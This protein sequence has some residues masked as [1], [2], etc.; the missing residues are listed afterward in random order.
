MKKQSSSESDH[1]SSPLEEP[2]FPA[3]VYSETVLAVNF[4]DSKK[5]FLEALL[6]IHA[7]HT[8]MLAR[9]GII[10][11]DEASTCL[12]ALQQLDLQA[13]RSAIYDGTCEDLFFYIEQQ[14]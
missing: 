2:A 14:L 5:Y 9:Q 6:E 3:R 10:T 13:I 11:T 1:E 8:L 7:A 4:E 12:R